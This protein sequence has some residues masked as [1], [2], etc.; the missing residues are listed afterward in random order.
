[1]KCKEL[2]AM[3][4]YGPEQLSRKAVSY[5]ISDLKKAIDDGTIIEGVVTKCD[6]KLNVEVK[7]EP[8]IVGSIAPDEFEYSLNDK[9]L[10]SIAVISKVG[11]KIKFKIK[12]LSKDAESGL[13]RAILSRRE[14]QIDCY[15]NYISKLK[16]GQVIDARVT[17]V[18]KY[19]AFCD[20]GCGFVAL[21]PV[22]NICIPRISNPSRDLRYMGNLKVIVKNIDESGRITLTHKELL[23]T[24]EEEVAK[25]QEGDTV[26]G[27]VRI[28]EDYGVFVE[29]TSNLVGLAD[30][31]PDVAPGDSV[32]VY[33]K[34]IIPEKMKIKLLIIS[35]N[36]KIF[37]PIHYDYKLPE[38]GFLFDW[39]YSPACSD[40]KFET[41]IVTDKGDKPKDSEV[42]TG[43]DKD[44]VDTA[45]E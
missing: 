13:Y 20:I 29:L 42:S 10:K 40:R 45:V 16:L 9:P 26:P 35:K 24:W 34:A 37:K 39:V 30:V 41:H 3:N 11:K 5:R 8:N 4:I 33:I 32:S 2:N 18:E 43:A 38:S 31:Y 19:G 22:E 17:Y 7:I 21:L 28:I 15:E 12:S 6:S 27:I 44:V 36:E 1:M 14:A 25:F 23:G